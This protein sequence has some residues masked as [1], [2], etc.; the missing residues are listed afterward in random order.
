MLVPNWLVQ[1]RA[2]VCAE[3]SFKQNCQSTMVLMLD[4]TTCPQNKFDSLQNEI[5]EKA[6]PKNAPR[7]SGCCDPIGDGWGAE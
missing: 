5:A 3:C 1:K 6:W 7:I 4:S 2:Q